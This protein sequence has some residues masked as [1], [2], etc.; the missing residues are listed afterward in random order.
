MRELG[1]D[2]FR[3]SIAWPRILPTGAAGRMRPGLDFYDRLV[4]ELLANEIEPY[5]TLYHWDLPQ[6]L[7]DRGGWPSR[8]TVGAFAEYV[9]V[10]ARRLG[11][12]VAHVDH[13]ER[14]LGD[15]VARLRSRPARA[16]PP[17]R[18]PMR[19][20]PR[21][22]SSWHMAAPPRSSGAMPRDRGSGSRSTS[23]RSSPV[24]DSAADRAAARLQDGVRN[25]W[26]LD[27]V[28]RGEY[29]ADIVAHY[30]PSLPTIADGDLEAIAAPIDFMGVNY[31]TRSV[32]HASTAG[33]AVAAPR[34]RTSNGR[35]WAGRSTRRAC[36]GCSC[37]LA[38]DYEIPPLYITENGAAYVDGRRHDGSVDDPE[39]IAYLEGPHRR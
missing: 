12:R 7:E 38:E 14:A 16:R 32:V 22:T 3:F 25:R 29:P 5:V 27:P 6:A 37:A 36:I 34:R 15:L 39:R 28:L 4:D 10:V 24:T 35:R 30:G 33:T 26:F 18:A 9:E 1:L 11:D 21:T 13:A 31:Y 23:S 8:D 2:A 20:Q 17:E 19:W